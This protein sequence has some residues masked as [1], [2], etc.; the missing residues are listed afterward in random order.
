[1]MLHSHE[2]YIS[3]VIT[4]TNSVGWVLVW[5]EPKG[6][7]TVEPKTELESSTADK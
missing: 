4:S 2:P 5:Q 1:M 6:D 7:S 3:S